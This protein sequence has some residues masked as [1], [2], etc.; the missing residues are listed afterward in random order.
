[1]GKVPITNQHPAWGKVIFLLYA[2]FF[3]CEFKGSN[4]IPTLCP[5]R[6]GLYPLRLTLDLQHRAQCLGHGR[7]S[8]KTAEWSKEC[9]WEW[10]NLSRVPL[11]LSSL[12]LARFFWI[13][14]TAQFAL[15]P[16]PHNLVTVQWVHKI[17]LNIWPSVGIPRENQAKLS[18]KEILIIFLPWATSPSSQNPPPLPDHLCPDT[19]LPRGPHP[20]TLAFPM[21]LPC[22][23]LRRRCP[24]PL[25]PPHG[26]LPPCDKNGSHLQPLI[27]RCR[28]LWHALDLET[29]NTIWKSLLPN[30]GFLPLNKLLDPSETQFTH[31]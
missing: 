20:M 13:A 29:E 27:F 23:G 17:C 22:Q 16:T 24:A 30:I 26:P 31:L 14:Q 3:P 12:I 10:N 5:Q 25:F 1:M 11:A 4:E 19:A 18:Q 15:S 8:V 7:A 6:Q 21:A 28:G 9:L 2:C